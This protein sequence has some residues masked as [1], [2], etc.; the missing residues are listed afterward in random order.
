VSV[1]ETHSLSFS[2]YEIGV[3]GAL[4]VGTLN[5]NIKSLRKFN[6]YLLCK[7]ADLFFCVDLVNLRVPREALWG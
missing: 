7:N 1:K 5:Y 2:N 6:N 4:K 3:S